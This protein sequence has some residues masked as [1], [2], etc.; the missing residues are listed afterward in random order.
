MYEIAVLRPDGLGRIETLGLT[1][2]LVECDFDSELAS[3]LSLDAGWR[4]DLVICSAFD[5]GVMTFG[6]RGDAAGQL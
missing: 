4:V 5:S 2:C 6:F 3:S 1:Q